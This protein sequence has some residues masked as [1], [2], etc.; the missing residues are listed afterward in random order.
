MMAYHL[1]E[2]F[3]LSHAPQNRVKTKL[4]RKIDNLID[5]IKLRIGQMDVADAAASVRDEVLDLRIQL[6]LNF[7]DASTNDYAVAMNEYTAENI[8]MGQYSALAEEVA[9]VLMAH[10]KIFVS[11]IET[12]GIEKFSELI[13]FD[14]DKLEDKLPVLNYPIEA[15]KAWIEKSQDLEFALI[16]AQLVLSGELPLRKGKVKELI[17]FMDRA[18]SSYGG[19]SIFLKIWEPDREVD[20][21]RLTTNMKILAS[22]YSFDYNLNITTYSKEELHQLLHN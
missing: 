17:T 6:F 19:Y 14:Q 2:Q 20:Q 9:E 11:I 8:Q 3:T 18:I 7:A 1:I 15:V 21:S 16:A 4:D 13:A 10:E 22:K 5:L 12:M